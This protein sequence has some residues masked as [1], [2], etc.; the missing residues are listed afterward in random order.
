MN[1]FS[2][3]D[4]NE[5]KKQMCRPEATVRF[6]LEL[7]EL[8]KNSSSTIVIF[9]LVSSGCYFLL[10]R[11]VDLN[12]NFYYFSPGTGTRVASINLAD[13]QQSDSILFA[14]TWT[15]DEINLHMLPIINGKNGNLVTAT[16]SLSDRQFQVGQDG[17]AYEIPH[18]SNSNTIIYKNGK[19][20]IR[21][22]AINT[23]NDTISSIKLLTNAESSEGYV[24]ESVV[25]NLS[26]AI[27]VTGFEAYTKKR[28]L[29]LEMEGISPNLKK[30]GRKFGL[31]SEK[32]AGFTEEANQKN[33]SLLEFIINSKRVV[34]F[35]NFNK[36]KDAFN[37]CY[38]LI[39]SEV[40]SSEEK[41]TLIKNVISYRHKII[42]V[43]PSLSVLNLEKVPDEEPVFPTRHLVKEAI[44]T[45][46]EFIK[47]LHQSTLSL[48]P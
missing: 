39:F 25:S 5:I 14:F 44:D 1:N 4:I 34:N 7:P 12:V 42:H 43:S 29:E 24:F 26:L 3:C 19:A 23:W 41:T 22:T 10:E 17:I 37:G 8:F 31:S 9:E 48:R 13:V 36:C 18:A 46:D 38:G 15:P 27:L 21:P 33:E 2:Q 32:I 47:S 35:Q 45:F 28:F 16:G 30:L 40:V 11:S 20:L 6:D